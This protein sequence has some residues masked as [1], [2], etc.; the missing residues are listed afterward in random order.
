MKRRSEL[1]RAKACEAVE[2]ALPVGVR[3]GLELV[4]IQVDSHEAYT[5]VFEI[6][7]SACKALQ[8]TSHDWG[9]YRLS[10]FITR[11]MQFNDGSG[12][13]PD[14]WVD[15]LEEC[16]TPP[17]PEGLDEGPEMATYIGWL[18]GCEYYTSEP[19]AEDRAIELLSELH[20]AMTVL[21]K[22]GWGP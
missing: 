11:T 4:G 7:L 20:Q 19:D 17:I 16:E 21:D 13:W 3:D 2:R 6:A 15:Y 8:I 12:E 5:S 10:T 18:W 1:V 9:M 14:S 22:N